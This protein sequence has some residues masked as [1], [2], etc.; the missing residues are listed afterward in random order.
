MGRKRIYDELEGYWV[1]THT[2]PDGM[3]Y[4]GMSGAKYICNRWRPCLYKNTGLCC[5]IDKWGWDNIKHEIIK[6]G[7]TKEEAFE[8]EEE[9]RLFCE[10]N[11]VSLNKNRTGMVIEKSG[12]YDE[13]HAL[14]R[15]E[16]RD[17]EKNRAKEW[18][19]NNRE[20]H[21]ENCRR[22][23]DEN[24]DYAKNY[25]NEH[26]EEQRKRVRDYNREHKEENRERARIWYEK[27]RVVR[28]KKDRI[29]YLK[30]KWNK[31]MKENGYISLF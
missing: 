30:K 13:Y 8:M 22:W 14:Y 23:F 19:K 16:H 7:L 17:S 3:V 24:P 9:I 27:N 26:K 18:R 20:R 2:T 28:K 25:Y 29:R 21:R 4:T 5:E 11:G 6:D 10:K 1:Y 15:E 31:E 12:G